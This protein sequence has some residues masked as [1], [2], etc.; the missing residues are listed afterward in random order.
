MLGRAAGSG[1]EGTRG[2][3]LGVASRERASLLGQRHPRSEAEAIVVGRLDGHAV[4]LGDDMAPDGLDDGRRENRLQDPGPDLGMAGQ[5]PLAGHAQDATDV[6]QEAGE[7]HRE[8]V[9]T[10]LALYWGS[11]VEWVWGC[12]YL[13]VH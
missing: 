12:S 4:P 3:R 11:P 9:A 7:H 13:D 5:T 1:V 2:E 10:D 6:V 8:F